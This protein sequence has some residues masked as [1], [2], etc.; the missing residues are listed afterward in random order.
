G[1]LASATSTGGSPFKMIGRLGDSSIIGSGGYACEV[2]AVSSTGNGESFMKLNAAKLA[3]DLIEKGYTPQM[4]A[5]IVI[6]KIAGIGG[7]GGIILIDKKG[8]IGYHFNTIRMAYAL[9]SK[10]GYLDSG[11]DHK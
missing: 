3:T 8:R 6:D 1:S 9:I 2:A 4:A 7:F 10:D 5:K 11:I